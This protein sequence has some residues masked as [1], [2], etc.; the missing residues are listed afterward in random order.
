[1]EA[2][3][4]KQ[5][6]IWFFRLLSTLLCLLVFAWIFSNSLQTGEVSGARS[7]AVTDALQGAV[8]AISPDSPI[9]TAQGE[10]YESLHNFVRDLA[11]FSEFALLGALLVWCYLSYTRSKAFAFLPVALVWFTPLVDEYLQSFVDGRGAELADVLVDT[12]GGFCGAAIA[13]LIFLTGLLF[14]KIKKRKKTEQ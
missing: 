7:E 5:W 13:F 14:S 3:N 2:K 1:M 8:G 4:E 11:H 12:C 10:A 6:K 9:A